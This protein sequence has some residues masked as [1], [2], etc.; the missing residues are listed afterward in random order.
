MKNILYIAT[1]AIFISFTSCK[2]SKKTETETSKMSEV[3]AIHDEV[4]PKMGTLGKLVGQL[5]PMADSLG[6]ES[7]EFKAMKDLQE[8]NRSMMDW[9]QGF[10]DRFDA[11]EILNGKDLSD[12]KKKWLLEEEEK[13]KQVKEN[14]NSSIANAEKILSKK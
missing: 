10:G 9:M 12:E 11:D 8:A 4:M 2:E 3:M 13:V 14:I 5:K 6:V 1:I 7:V